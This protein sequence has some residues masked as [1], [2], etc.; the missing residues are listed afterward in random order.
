M[1]C[2]NC[3][4]KIQEVAAFCQHCGS[5]KEGAKFGIKANF[6]LF[7]L[8]GKAGLLLVV[9]GFF[10][11]MACRMNGLQ[12]A[13]NM[14]SHNLL[15]NNIVG[16]FMYA[17]FVSALVGVFIGALLLMGKNIPPEADWIAVGVCIGCAGYAM[18]FS[19]LGNGYELVVRN[20]VLQA[21]LGHGFYVQLQSGFY[22]VLIGLAVAL[23]SQIL[24]EM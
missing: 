18:M 5:K 21:R 2:I 7:R 10:M 1:F 3:G 17:L 9:L 12:L 13:D 19:F 6:R 22:I 23:V 16:I 4:K 24:D 15:D 11:P 14:I 20:S 8:I